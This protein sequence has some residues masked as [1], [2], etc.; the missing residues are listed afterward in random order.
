VSKCGFVAVVGRP[1]VGKSTLLNLLLGEKIALVSHKANATRK[2]LKGIVM[3]DRDQIIFVD[4]PGLHA[5]DKELN[6]YM[7]NEAVKAIGDADLTLFI[8]DTRRSLEDYEEFLTL[9]DGRPHIVI[10]NKTDLLSKEELTAKLLEYGKFQSKFLEIVPVSAGKGRGTK[11][12]LDAI[13]SHL[14][15]SPY[16]YDPDY[17]TD[18]NTRDIY[19]EIIRE[20]LFNGLSDELPYE[21]D[22]IIDKI[23][24]SE[25]LDKIRATIVVNRES[26]KGMVIGKGGSALKRI[27]TNAR[28]SL[29]NFSGKK[30]FLELFVRVEKGWVSDKSKLKSF[31]YDSEI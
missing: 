28:H 25:K 11:N 22:I 17:I 10:I 2:R 20:E 4:T 23:E 9:A 1:N 29:E 30:I 12:L 7:M 16:L 8:T 15:E 3:H 18:E 27:G 5:R 26:Q 31:G 14:P 24:E 13:C 19:K 6:I 21:A